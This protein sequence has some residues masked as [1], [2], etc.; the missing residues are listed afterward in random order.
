MLE[1]DLATQRDCE[2]TEDAHWRERKW[3]A[4]RQAKAQRQTERTGPVREVWCG[5]IPYTATGRDLRERL[6]LFGQVERVHLPA[7]PS[8][9]G[10]GA[11]NR[12]FGFITFLRPESA[13]EAIR[14]A[15]LNQVKLGSRP[16][17]VRPNHPKPGQRC[18]AAPTEAFPV[19]A[20]Q[21]GLD[22][23]L[24]SP[25]AFACAWEHHEG[26]TKLKAFGSKRKISLF[27]RVKVSLPWPAPPW[28]Q[29]QFYMKDVKG[30]VEVQPQ[31]GDKTVLLFT[32]RHPPKAFRLDPGNANADA[33]CEQPWLLDPD[34]RGAWLR[35]TAEQFPEPMS[36]FGSYLSIRLVVAGVHDAP[37]IQRLLGTLAQ[38]H[39]VKEPFCTLPPESPAFCHL[40]VRSA[41]EEEAV[42]VGL[43]SS[44]RYELEVLHS[45]GKLHPREIDFGFSATL[46]GMPPDQAVA[47]LRKIGV[48]QT[49][50]L[51][52][53]DQWQPA[54]STPAST[55]LP[56]RPTMVQSLVEVMH[57]VVTP[58]RLVVMAPE[59]EVSNRMLRSVG[60]SRLL[61][62]SFADENFNTLGQATED[63]YNRILST[64]RGGIHVGGRFFEL[65][66]F[67]SSQLKNHGAWF[68][69]ADP[70]PCSTGRG[71]GAGVIR[72]S[73][74]DFAHIMIPGK[75]A[76]RMG[77]C[78]STTTA[79][80]E[81][82]DREWHH[83]PDVE[84]GGFCFS[85][86]VGTISAEL[87]KEVADALDLCSVPSALQIRF[88]GVKGVVA[89]DPMLAGRR[90]CTR[91]SMEKFESTARTLEVCSLATVLP[92][93]LNRQL[94]TLLSTL[95]VPNCVFHRLQREM[96]E[97][98]DA[99]LID[100]VAAVAMLTSLGEPRD[101]A[102]ATAL[103]MLKAG[104]SVRDEPYLAPLVSAVHA[105]VLHGLSLKSRIRVP[106]G[107]LLMGVLDE[108]A[109]LQPGE[110]FI[111]LAVTTDVVTGTVVVARNPCL[112]CGDILQLCAVDRPALHHL[113]SCI[114]F[115]Q[116]GDRPHPDE[117][118]GGDLDGDL[119]FVTWDPSLVP[120][121]T[122]RAMQYSGGSSG[123]TTSAA[124]RDDGSDGFGIGLELTEIFSSLLLSQLEP[125][126]SESQPTAAASEGAR[127]VDIDAVKDFFVK[128]MQNDNL[129]VIANTH[130]ALAD[131]S[132]LG[133]EDPKCI[134]LAQ[135]HSKAVD[136]PKSG[137]PA[138]FPIE[139]RVNKYPDFMG[140]K[141]KGN[142][143]VYN[144][145]KVL[146]ELYRLVPAIRVGSDSA[147]SVRTV[148][149]D[150]RFEVSGFTD[151]LDDAYRLRK[152]YNFELNALMNQ[153]GVRGEAE[154]LTGR[155][156]KFYRRHA[157]AKRKFDLRQQ[158]V[159][160]VRQLRR[161]A[162]EA[163][164]TALDD[165]VARK[166][167]SERVV[168]IEHRVASAWYYC[169][170]HPDAKNSLQLLSFA[171]TADHILTRIT[172][173]Q[174]EP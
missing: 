142:K 3:R 79:S 169:T 69:A 121:R 173:G 19:A 127:P 34:E 64:L 33:F 172:N 2:L 58:L 54:T 23:R 1:Q 12:G 27:L 149:Y 105:H 63:V 122:V 174:Q 101:G 103:R 133:A 90:M 65:L 50:P 117:T 78:F 42:V 73:M 36:M 40:K 55:L 148:V 48:E 131:Q 158:V 106:D 89:L 170:Y 67:S 86:G 16:L 99:M 109:T 51:A 95:G 62:V 100:S 96:I 13:G 156:L 31:P 139:L 22:R 94:I 140:K 134:E 128:F 70:A 114:V 72:A 124:S 5:N 38:Y 25:A 83:I 21:L 6:A 76:A 61:R 151:Y 7:D 154:L 159:Q 77:Q 41:T 166:S 59:L 74:G 4:K 110:V 97:G 15:E 88:G 28:L 17:R 108:T 168:T 60:A 35:T 14:A 164:D 87:M 32:V 91:P 161:W 146:G 49:A 29:L 138:R 30:N 112:H 43:E 81:I 102:I 80:V 141:A 111:R 47:M 20:V 92:A 8:S 39:L 57:V 152:I 104:L 126:C 53:F 165:A 9:F 132:L 18:P 119:Y 120:P 145:T 37:Q 71:A 75:Y 115:P 44:V 160:A 118:S 135:L 116:L 147:T 24:S 136:F 157:K 107:A 153:F 52:E 162:K 68:V 167:D 98:I 137:E 45:A 56:R 82:R 143:T 84:R 11:R 93:Y 125:R 26:F 171:W 10:F 46:Q 150:S 155:I 129:G 123:G 66:A 113:R 163:L 144:S 85:D 130:L